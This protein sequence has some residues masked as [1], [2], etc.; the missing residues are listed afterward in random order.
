MASHIWDVVMCNKKQIARMPGTLE[1]VVGHWGCCHDD[2]R[3]NGCFTVII[4]FL[5]GSLRQFTQLITDGIQPTC[6]VIHTHTTHTRTGV[7]SYACPC[8]QPAATVG[9]IVCV[10]VSLSGLI[11]NNSWLWEDER[12]FWLEA[13]VSYGER[14]ISTSSFHCSPVDKVNAP[15]H[16]CPQ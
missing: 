13:C 16:G 8:R 1:M 11:I 12:L 15:S 5:I 14:D 2:S 7:C 4:F 3:A 10:S 9:N 6:L